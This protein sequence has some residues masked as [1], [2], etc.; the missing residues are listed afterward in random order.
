MAEQRWRIRI[1]PFDAVNAVLLTAVALV[2][3]LPMIHMLALSFSSSHAVDAK[4]VSLWPRELTLQPYLFVVSE[5][6]FYR[7]F[8]VSVERTLLGVAVN[9]VLT[10]LAAY[11]L[12]K[13][14]RA[15]GARD[16]Y[17]WFFM[18]SILF[19]GGLI[20][21]YLVITWTGLIN[22]IWALILPGAVPV[23]NVILLHNFF[24]QLPPEIEESALIDGASHWTIMSRIFVPLSMPA[25][26]TLV[27]F[28]AV[29]HWNSWFDGMILMSDPNRY[30]LQTY[31]QSVLVRRD[32]KLIS[33]RDLQAYIEVNQRNSNAAKIIVAMIPILACYPFLQKYF[34]KGIILGSVKG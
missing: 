13:T 25:L 33:L 29:G 21:W 24:R 9:M 23:F 15:F 5:G 10:V 1:R 7:A 19:S 28:C 20:P 22:R 16:W 4:M 27:L 17:V 14:R 8:I 26:A 30:P 34:T 3:I 11:P 18:V 2:C 6:R 31:L 12:S 32:L